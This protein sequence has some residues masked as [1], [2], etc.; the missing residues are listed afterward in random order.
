MLTSPFMRFALT[1][2][3]CGLA[4]VGCSAGAQAPSTPSAKATVSAAQF[5]DAHGLTGLSAQ[6]IVEKLDATEEDRA[7]GPVGSVRADQ[8]LL[9]DAA[10]SATL[11]MPADRFYLSVAPYVK[12]THECFNH[13]LATCKGELAGETVHVTVVDASGATLVD[14][15]KTLY[16]NGFVGLWLP[17]QI[18]GTITVT[19]DGK[20]A[21]QPISTGSQDPTCLTTVQLV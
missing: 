7:A 11:P 1:S 5:A 20:T 10:T 2:I 6:Q 21:T 19:Y 12:T 16:A 14:A 15:D 8:L 3:G 17:K 18:T 13:N 4:L 9:S